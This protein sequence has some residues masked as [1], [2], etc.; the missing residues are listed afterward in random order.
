MTA[1]LISLDEAYR[2]Y[3]FIKEGKWPRA[4][5]FC[6]LLMVPEEIHGYWYNSATWEP[7]TR[8]YCNR[9]FSPFILKALRNVVDRG[10]MKE[11]K[12][13]DGCWNVRDVRGHPGFVSSHAYA[14][15]IDI[16]AGTNQ[17]GT[18]GDISLDLASCFTDAG[19][20]HGRGFKRQD[21]MHFSCATW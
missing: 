12:T 8:I 18:Y 3:G 19:M 15:S 10:L 2:R 21:P 20:I 1:G 6:E 9:D 14:L 17:L 7:V 11:L 4:N 5:E 13:Y 16:N